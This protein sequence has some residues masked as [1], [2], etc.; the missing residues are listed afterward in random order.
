[1]KISACIFDLDGVLV[2]SAKY[3][4]IAWSAL[5]KKLGFEF[6]LDDNERLK[7]VSRMR[8]LDILLEIGKISMTEEEKIKAADEKN[9]L[10]KSYVSKMTPQEIL[11]GTEDFL[12]DVKA[13]GLSTAIGSASKNTQLIIGCTGLD[14]YFDAVADGTI[15]SKAKPD[16]EVFLKAAAM[17]GVAPSQCVVFEDAQA[18]I[19]AAVN[20]GMI[21]V[22]VGD[23]NILYQADIVIPDFI[24]MSFDSLASL[25]I[26]KINN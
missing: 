3:H 7:G 24:N 5:A 12:K 17:L 8:S 20:A 13:H 21:A 2:D 26:K 11:P 22:G 14:K 9:E 10:Y 4:F 15:V 6:T 16:P 25:L 1:M 18:G 23:K 19:Q